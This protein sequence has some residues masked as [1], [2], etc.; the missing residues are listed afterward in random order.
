MAWWPAVLVTGGGMLPAGDTTMAPL[1]LKYRL[2]PGH[3]A[4][5]LPLNQQTKK[6]VTVQ[7]G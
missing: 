4:L 3:F 2:T 5:L 1:N 6:A 7:A